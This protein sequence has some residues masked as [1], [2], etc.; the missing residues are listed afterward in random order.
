[1]RSSEMVLHA[2]QMSHGT[3]RASEWWSTQ[4][5]ETEM[6]LS[7]S[8]LTVGRHLLLTRRGVYLSRLGNRDS[9][10]AAFEA[11]LACLPLHSKATLGQY[12]VVMHLSS[13]HFLR[14][15]FSAAAGAFWAAFRGLPS[16]AGP[17]D[18]YRRIPARE[19]LQAPWRMA[20][21][22]RGVV[23]VLTSNRSA[24][25]ADLRHALALWRANVVG[26]GTDERECAEVDG[27]A[28]EEARHPRR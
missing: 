7:N 12:E 25:L 10:L 1:M 28:E 19:E 18:A 26:A 13:L 17:L 8:S 22:R 11:A 21:A 27:G 3:P 16:L 2:D 24:D 14:G 6:L 9:A 23:V 5:Q 15:D 20:A 4:L